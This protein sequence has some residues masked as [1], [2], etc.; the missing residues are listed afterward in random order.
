MTEDHIKHMVN[1]FLGWKL[2]PSFMP[3]GGITYVQPTSSG[4]FSPPIAIRS[5]PGPTGTN[6]LSATQA[7]ATS[8]RRA[9]AS[10]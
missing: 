8:T 4:N 10:R 7:E 1:R 5:H 6:L 3:D 2:P 9:P